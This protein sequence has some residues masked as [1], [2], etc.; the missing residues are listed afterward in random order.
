[1]T[2]PL[3]FGKLPQKPVEAKSA[4]KPLDFGAVKIP[5][6]PEP[7]KVQAEAAKQP[8]ALDF[9]SVSVPQPKPVVSQAPAKVETRASFVDKTDSMVPEVL[10][11][12]EQQHPEL[13]KDSERRMK[14]ELQI[15]QLLPLTI[16]VVIT[17][18]EKPMSFLGSQSTAVINLVREISNMRAYE[19]VEEAQKSVTA[20]PTL[21]QRLKGTDLVLSYKPKLATIRANIGR[22]LSE[23]DRLIQDT[24]RTEVQMTTCMATFGTVLTYVGT[25]PD[26]NLDTASHQ[27]RM[28]LNQAAMQV[29]SLVLQ[30]EQQQT[31]LYTM[32]NMLDTFLD[33]T[34][35][36]YETAKATR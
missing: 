29:Q 31:M 28:T 18:G 1:M 14:A 3:D 24:K 10:K 22:W 26:N 30:I 5:T 8:K 9:G 23:A 19:T 15:K 17:W 25:I 32:K 16:Q 20:T 35:P 12:F 34:L 27:R 36:A 11:L 33:V 13:Y 2:A 7:K 6:A 21:F 4:G